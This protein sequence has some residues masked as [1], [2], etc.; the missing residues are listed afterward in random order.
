MEGRGGEDRKRQV[1]RAGGGGNI[2]VRGRNRV[3]SR[4]VKIKV[5]QDVRR[6][7]EEERAKV[8]DSAMYR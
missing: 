1:H 5:C 6:E 2:V 8:Q 4:K 7:E 3:G